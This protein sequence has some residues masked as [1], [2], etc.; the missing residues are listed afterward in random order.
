MAIN[1]KF[2]MTFL[3]M[4]DIPKKCVV[5]FIYLVSMLTNKINKFIIY[6]VRLKEN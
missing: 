1:F 2:N 6:F 4:L 3:L 5:V